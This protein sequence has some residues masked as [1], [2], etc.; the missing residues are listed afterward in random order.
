MQHSQFGTQGLT[1]KGQGACWDL[2]LNCPSAAPALSV[3]SPE[4]KHGLA[5]LRQPRIGRSMDEAL[6]PL[7]LCYTVFIIVDGKSNT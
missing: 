2:R 7:L 3:K 1:R 6:F 4:G 5:S